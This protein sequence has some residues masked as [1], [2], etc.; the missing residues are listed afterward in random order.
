MSSS[1]GSQDAS[2]NVARVMD[3]IQQDVQRRRQAGE[4]PEERER[5]L[6]RLFLA[7]SPGAD[8]GALT[9]ALEQV[10]RATFVDPLVPIDS[11]RKAGAV[12]KKGMRSAAL[13][14]VSWLTHQI[15]QFAVATSRSLHIIER[16]LSDFERTLDGHLV[17]STLVEFPAL[18]RPD[19]WWVDA[20]IGAV[21]GVPGRA[22]HAA[23]GADDWL[24]RRI[25][26]AG[27]DAYGVDPRFGREAELAHHLQTL[28]PGALGAVVLSAVTE[29]MTSIERSRLLRLVTSRLADDGVLV[30]HSVTP[31]TWLSADAPWQA[32][33]APG[34]PLRGETW[35]Q[36]L[37][38]DGY[39][40]SVQSGADGTDYLVIAH[41]QGG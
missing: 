37:K 7:H 8:H 10:D 13:W 20:A 39:Q 9:E 33:L 27:G 19:A 38:G 11:N 22:L 15:N 6:D 23:A 5:E 14:Y 30:V 29:G 28:V 18:H 1:Q 31:S 36:L 2:T 35:C 41:R 24:V 40:A 32:D 34:R 25:V 21:T 17:P 3:E 12:V 4:L 16:R 26:S